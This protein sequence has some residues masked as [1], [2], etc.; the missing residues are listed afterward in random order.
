MEQPSWYSPGK[1]RD[2]PTYIR[3]LISK[4]VLTDHIYS[5]QEIKIEVMKACPDLK[6]F[7]EKTYAPYF[8]DLLKQCQLPKVDFNGNAQITTLTDQVFSLCFHCLLQGTINRGNN[9]AGQYN[10]LN[11]QKQFTDECIENYVYEH[12]VNLN[13]SPKIYNLCL[14]LTMWGYTKGDEKFIRNSS[15]QSPD[16]IANVKSAFENL[17]DNVLSQFNFTKNTEI[18]D[19]SNQ[20]S[21]VDLSKEYYFGSSKENKRN[22]IKF[23]RQKKLIRD[24]I[25]DSQKLLDFKKEFQT[26]ENRVLRNFHGLPQEIYEDLKKLLVNCFGYDEVVKNNEEVLWKMEE[27]LD[28]HITENIT[29]IDYMEECYE[30]LK[31]KHFDKI[32]PKTVEPPK[33]E[34]KK[35]PPK[36][37]IKKESD[38]EEEEEEEE[39]KQTEEQTA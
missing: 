22:A 23:E 21:N 36:E 19:I 33:E 9:I 35:E 17:S 38:N 28:E 29:F 26:M 34:I 31:T 5:L 1:I 4:L 32:K 39:E 25:D 6:V 11:W 24:T 20:L 2:R 18:Q 30:R 37:E 16:F 15:A 7:Q 8:Y 12:K 3:N 27:I 10:G 13:L 14:F